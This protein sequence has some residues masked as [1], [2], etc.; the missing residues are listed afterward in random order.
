MTKLE[1]LMDEYYDTLTVHKAKLDLIYN[2]LTEI[3]GESK[4]PKTIT[5]VDE[6]EYEKGKAI[7]FNNEKYH[8]VKLELT[9]G[10]VHIGLRNF[11]TDYWLVDEILWYSNHDLKT[12]VIDEVAKHL[13]YNLEIGTKIVKETDKN[14]KNKRKNRK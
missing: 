10:E 7:I 2:T 14:G 13:G 6:K 12:L 9:K 1:K 4:L 5:L 8:V 3:W 11:N